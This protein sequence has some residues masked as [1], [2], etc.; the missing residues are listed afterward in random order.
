[1]R[2][3]RNFAK[4]AAQQLVQRTVEGFCVETKT[5]NGV[6]KSVSEKR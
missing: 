2:D 6:E 1:M 5:A 4:K 3:H